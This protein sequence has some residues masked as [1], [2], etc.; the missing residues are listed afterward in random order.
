MHE[1]DILF[2]KVGDRNKCIFAQM[3]SCQTESWEASLILNSLP[4][5]DPPADTTT[6]TPTEPQQKHPM[7]QSNDFPPTDHPGTSNNPQTTTTQTTNL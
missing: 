4:P 5:M 3:N 2:I 7:N 6:T 1:E